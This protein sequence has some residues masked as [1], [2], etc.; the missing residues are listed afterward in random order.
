MH[1]LFF[2]ARSRVGGTL[3]S[4]MPPVALFGEYISIVRYSLVWYG[5]S[6]WY[7]GG[8]GPDDAESG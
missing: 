2:L 3:G 5:I 7:D 4:T 1:P 8:V 6:T